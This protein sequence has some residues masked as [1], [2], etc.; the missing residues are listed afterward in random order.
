MLDREAG[1]CLVYERRP[2]A[3]RTYG[4]YV[5]RGV[6]LHCAMI[7][8]AVDA[9]P[10]GDVT[11][12]LDAAPDAAEP[13]VVWGNAESVDTALMQVETEAGYV[14]AR[15]PIALSEPRPLTEW[16][17]TLCELPPGGSVRAPA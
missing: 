1:A 4:F 3:C 7:T 15:S 11:Q 17:L 6:G 9:R 13:P 5:E 10:A 8:E 16:F 14:L 2:G 12:A